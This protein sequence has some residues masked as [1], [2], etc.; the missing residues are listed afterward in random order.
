MTRIALETDNLEL[1]YITTS[2]L[3]IENLQILV[4][5]SKRECDQIITYQ[6][7][8]L[9]YR[10]FSKARQILEKGEYLIP[11]F[12]LVGRDMTTMNEMKSIDSHERLNLNNIKLISKLVLRVY[13]RNVNFMRR[14]Y[15]STSGAPRLS[16]QAHSLYAT[17]RQELLKIHRNPSENNWNHKLSREIET[18]LPKSVRRRN[19]DR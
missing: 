1:L 2:V 13:H 16:S 3:S 7:L 10:S 8:I 17:C 9:P 11:Y 15:E 14:L 12:V 5:L 6:N 4:K 18:R 19:F